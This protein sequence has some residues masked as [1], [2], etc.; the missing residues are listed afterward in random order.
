MCRALRYKHWMI[1]QSR[2]L[3]GFF[4][5][6]A[7]LLCL[8]S[9]CGT[10]VRYV[11]TNTSPVPMPPVSTDRVTV[12]ASGPPARPFVEVGMI[13]ARQSST[14]SVDEMPE[15]IAEMRKRA[16]AEGCHGLV[17]TGA[18]NTVA[19]GSGSATGEVYGHSSVNT[20][21]G[22]AGVCIVFTGEPVKPVE[23]VVSPQGAE[24]VPNESR[25]CHGPGGCR[26]GQSCM[27]DGKSF[28]TCDCGGGAE[29]VPPTSTTSDTATTGVP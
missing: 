16:A 23:T 29:S 5:L 21:E 25:L 17:I 2:M 1:R 3:P 22:F 27:P 19:G 13:Q 8:L 20:K 26:G 11:P 28:A 14:V 9:G 18:N 24:C 7:T 15:I 12:F 10:T 6:L 4:S